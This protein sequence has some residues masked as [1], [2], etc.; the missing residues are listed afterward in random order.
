MTTTRSPALVVRNAIRDG[1]PVELRAVDGVITELGTSVSSQ[2]DDVAL[3][4]NAMALVEG[5]VNGHTHAAMTLLRGQGSDRRLQ[6]WL[7]DVIWP[8]EARLTD[9]VVY[10][11]TRLA[12]VEMLRSGTTSFFDMYFHPG[13]VA[14]AAEEM[15]IRATV[16]APLFDHADPSKLSMLQRTAGDALDELA[17]TGPLITPCLNPHAIYTV[18]RPSLEWIG[19]LAAERGLPVHIHLSETIREVDEWM[20]SNDDRPAVHLD[21]CGLLGPRTLLAHGCVLDDDELA[22]IAGRGATIV[23]NPVSNL[24]L[25][26]GATL[27]YPAV[28]R[29]GVAVGLGT[30]G[31]A[32]NNDLDLY[33]DLKVFALIQ[34]FLASDPTVLAAPEAI[35]IARGQ[36]SPL[37]GGRPIA[38]GAPADFVLVDTTLPQLNPGDLVDN[39][40]YAGAGSAVDTV[41]IAGRVVMRNR[42]VP[43]SDEIIEQA[44][45]WSRHLLP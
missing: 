8:A 19:A 42:E 40:V 1:S 36:R 6:E 16:G 27:D 35:A 24:K 23:T 7:T 13:Q 9:E 26:G 33:G 20:A 43:G 10:W 2:P 17:G 18:S 15:G 5:L 25:A 44:N 30:D 14:R 41:V 31:A 39:L 28:A 37:L 29:H 45:R 38:V 34:R 22:L 11:G 12:I 3:D 4:A 21:R 32:S